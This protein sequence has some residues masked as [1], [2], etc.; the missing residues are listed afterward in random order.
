M[1]QIHHL[2]E[3]DHQNFPCMIDANIVE[4]FKM[5]TFLFTSK[6]S[7]GIWLLSWHGTPHVRLWLSDFAIRKGPL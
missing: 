4:A 7:L 6:P 5:P 2:Q 1:R 3:S